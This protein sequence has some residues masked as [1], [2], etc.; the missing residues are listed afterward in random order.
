[1]SEYDYDPLVA[2]RKTTVGRLRYL[3][4]TIAVPPEAKTMLHSAARTTEELIKNVE[5]LV[6]LLG[7]DIYTAKG[8]PQDRAVKS[9]LKALEN[10]KHTTNKKEAA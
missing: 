4:E 7:D 8:L 5:V 3:A 2:D 10:I 1:M 9:T 6:E